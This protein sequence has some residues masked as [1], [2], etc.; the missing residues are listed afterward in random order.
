MSFLQ[1]LTRNLTD[2]FG[3]ALAKYS[4]DK[5]LLE[6]AMAATAMIS[7]ADGQVEPQEKAKLARFLETHE[8]M[9]HFDR[10]E[11]IRLF[12][13]YV[14]ELEFD[15]D[16][17]GDTCLKQIREVSGEEK[18]QLVARLAIA[19]AKADGEFEPEEKVAAAKIVDALNLNKAEFGLN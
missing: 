19:I 3:P 13:G 18:R 10:S 16:M 5:D 9:K 2:R 7:A 14:Q 17:G 12:N 15:L 8:L 6:G 1:G 4:R 11:A